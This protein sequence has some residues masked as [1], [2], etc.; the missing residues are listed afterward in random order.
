MDSKLEKSEKTSKTTQSIQTDMLKAQNFERRQ[1]GVKPRFA[2]KKGSDPFL[3]DGHHR[4]C[5]RIK[6][7][8][9]NTTSRNC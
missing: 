3:E 7:A 1:K 2:L 9:Q 8:D 4:I 5:L 6:A